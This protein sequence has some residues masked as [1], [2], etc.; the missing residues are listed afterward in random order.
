MKVAA[1]AALVAVA[2]LGAVANADLTYSDSTGELFDNGFTHL[3]ISSVTVGHDA[4]NIYFTI[5]TV[6]DVDAT[7]WGK[8]CIGINTPGSVGDSSGNAWG[9]N[10]NWNGQGI[11]F[12]AAA[13][14]DDGG[15]NFGGELRRMDNANN[16]D[17]TLLAAT[18]G[19]AGISGTATGTTVTFTLSRAL[20]GLNDGDT[21][22][23]DVLT[24]GGG[25][26]PGVDHLSRADRSTGGWGETSVAGTFLRYTVPAPGSMAMLGMGG[27][28]LA[29][30]RR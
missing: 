26:D 8:Y 18:Y 22:L 25:A 28:A 11:D 20:L 10:V 5:N 23:F 21:F 24:T 6:G 27:L 4:S 14:V 13:W 30:R 17:N 29:R 12:W 9:R 3:D 19:A 1:L 7:T 2:G 15:S 16:N